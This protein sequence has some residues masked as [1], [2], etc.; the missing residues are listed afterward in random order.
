M[1][2][3]S[4]APSTFSQL[5]S[6][7]IASERAAEPARNRTS[8]LLAAMLLAALVSALLVVADSVVDTYSDGHLL[9]GWICLWA[10]GFTA[11][12]LLADTARRAAAGV[13]HLVTDAGQRRV[14]KHADAYLLALAR[15][16]PR[17]MAD[18]QAA[19]Q[20]ANKATQT[21]DQERVQAWVERHPVGTFNAA[22]QFPGKRSAFHS[23][24]LAG[25]PTHLQYLPA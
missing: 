17:I 15:H 8:K 3:Q 20:R 1:S 19:I 4:H 23:T 14:Q 6:V 18:L 21:V 16:D 25:L 7:Q 13:I 2:G 24:P 9:L 11:I 22:Y 12:G 5:S 10:I